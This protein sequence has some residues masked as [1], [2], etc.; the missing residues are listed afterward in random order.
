MR[1]DLNVTVFNTYGSLQPGFLLRSQGLLIL[2]DTL[3]L[4]GDIKYKIS[5]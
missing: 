4:L 2:Q 1:K 5:Q 3:P